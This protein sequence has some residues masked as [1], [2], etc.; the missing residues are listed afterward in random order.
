MKL[1]KKNLK[2]FLLFLAFAIVSIVFA[3]SPVLTT[4]PIA[5]AAAAK[6][7]LSV[8]QVPRVNKK[9]DGA[10]GEKI[11]IPLLDKTK[12]SAITKYTVRVYDTSNTAHD[13]EVDASGE[14]VST[15]DPSNYFVYHAE[16]SEPNAEKPNLNTEFTIP[17]N[18]LE[19]KGLTN[20]RYEFQY[21]YKDE[22][23]H[24]YYS[25]K[26]SVEVVNPSYELVFDIIDQES[27]NFGLTQLIRKEFKTGEK[28][29]A[30]PIAYVKQQGDS[31][32]NMLDKVVKPKMS[33]YGGPGVTLTAEQEAQILV[34]NGDGSSYSFNPKQAGEYKF[35]YSYDNADDKT[36]TITVTEDYVQKDQNKFYAQTPDLTSL[37]ADNGNV[38][39]GSKNVV[40]PDV[41]VYEEDNNETEVAHNVTKIEIYK[42]D[43]QHSYKKELT[44][45]DFTF[46][47]TK[48]FFGQSSYDG[49]AGRWTI[50][51]TIVDINN[52]TYYKEVPLTIVDD[53]TPEVFMAYNYDVVKPD[54]GPADEEVLWNDGKL[55]GKL[56]GEAVNTDYSV[57]FK[58]D[59]YLTENTEF[60]LPAIYATHLTSDFNELTL[61]RYLT[62]NSGTYYIDN[63]QR[64]GNEVSKIG[65]SNINRN[66]YG[67]GIGSD[68]A[69]DNDLKTEEQKHVTTGQMNRV[70]RFKFTKDAYDKIE[71]G[72]EFSV[73]YYA[74]AKNG[75]VYNLRESGTEPYKFTIHKTAPDTAEDVPT[76]KITNIAND[77]SSVVFLD[78][79]Q[80]VNF[81]VKDSNENDKLKTQLF[82]YYGDVT[83]ETSL[84]D[85]LKEVNAE[86]YID[87]MKGNILD[88]DALLSKWK[89]KAG[90]STD[91]HRVSLNSSTANSYKFNFDDTKDKTG[92]VTIVLVTINDNGKI[93]YAARKL[94]IVD[95]TDNEAPT[96]DVTYDSAANWSESVYHATKTFKQGEEV[97]LPEVKFTDASQLGLEIYYYYT[98]TDGNVIINKDYSLASSLDSEAGT[99]KDVKLT[100][101]ADGVYYVVYVGNDLLNNTTCVYFSFD[102]QDDAELQLYVDVLRPDGGT[103]NSE[104]EITGS[105]GSQ[106]QFVRNATIGNKEPGVEDNITFEAPVI[107]G[108]GYSALPNLTYKF[109]KAGEFTF[110]F[111]A[112]VD[113]TGKTA[114]VTKT[115]KI[116]DPDEI[117]FENLNTV[118]FDGYDYNDTVFIPSVSAKYGNG[119]ATVEPKVTVDITNGK[120]GEPVEITEELSGKKEGWTFKIDKENAVYHIQYV[121]T[122]D[123][124]ITKTSQTYDI[125]VGD[126]KSRPTIK[127]SDSAKATLEKDI[128]FDGTTIEYT[129]TLDKANKKLYINAVAGSK[130]IIEKI[131]LGL[132]L[133]D[134][135]D[136]GQTTSVSNLWSNLTVE[137]RNANNTLTATDEDSDE[138]IKV[139]NITATGEYTIRLITHDQTPN[140]SLPFEIKFNVKQK[141]DVSH[142]NDTVVGI[143]LIVISL[144]V[145]AGV[146]LF[147]TFGGKKGGSKKSKKANK[148]E[149]TENTETS[150]NSNK[151]E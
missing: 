112:S 111:K 107:T 10:K 20:G 129:I 113:K 60:Y 126:N 61:V 85:A 69:T 37:K 87:T 125:K 96:A 108:V 119:R 55:N 4:L 136:K 144:V 59:I 15:T 47:F 98:D 56:S 2:V 79:E 72:E 127:V 64:N 63:L 44:N 27:P 115:I 101:M 32:N 48:E 91:V 11:I 104:G 140:E 114:E 43:D 142:V 14:A 23:G 50:K 103:V 58:K 73:Y 99:I 17:A 12:N 74:I 105:V 117:Q 81:T 45:N 46:D 124:G 38:K 90:N 68:G 25:N 121:A 149:L 33:Y 84:E 39:L 100:P 29:V 51:Y 109:N 36:I 139:Y 92:K 8:L 3:F 16:Q 151:V 88:D 97:V 78:E 1:V 148:K 128:E 5:E 141:A 62:S 102:V 42:A 70:T 94:T 150:D 35:T 77:N 66:A 133:E 146:I 57:D 26:F 21:I 145:L 76:I 131:D 95:A 147:F 86:N 30:L 67:E 122:T 53:A 143:V 80:T 18:S 28:Q 116:I 89:E 138:G 130:T 120:K 49:L 135:D 22:D 123:N 65:D 31:A 54:G 40:L 137:L 13:C 132:I 34:D 7:I 19:V 134:L 9:V 75:K 118:S 82:Y 24:T 52:Y 83:M 110:T 93:A 41:K 106:F 6:Q 71:D